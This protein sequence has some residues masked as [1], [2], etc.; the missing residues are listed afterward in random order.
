MGY[1]EHWYN[2]IA[3]VDVIEKSWKDIKWL[4]EKSIRDKTIRY[5]NQEHIR[6]LPPNEF[7]TL[8]VSLKSYLSHIDYETKIIDT[9]FEELRQKVLEE[10]KNKTA[11]LR[12]I[13]E[14]RQIS[15]AF[16]TRN[17]WDVSRYID[18]RLDNWMENFERMIWWPNNFAKLLALT[19][20]WTAK[21]L[22]KW[23]SWLLRLW[24]EISSAS[25]EYSNW[26][27]S[28]GEKIILILKTIWI[29]WLRAFWMIPAWVVSKWLSTSSVLPK[30][31][32]ALEWLEIGRWWKI[33][34]KTIMNERWSV[35]L[36]NWKE[37]LKES[38][39]I[40]SKYPFLKEYK[41]F[42]WELRGKDIFWE[43]QNA[44]IER[45]PY[46]EDLVVKI[47]KPWKVDS[48][49]LEY[50]SHEQFYITLRKWAKEFKGQ[51]SEEIKIPYVRKWLQEKQWIFEMEKIQWQNLATKFYREHYS[52]ELSKYPKKYLDK[53]TDWQFEVLID[54]EKLRK[55][56][57]M[58]LDWDFSGK[59]ISKEMKYFFDSKTHWTELW[60]VLDFL[61]WKWLKHTDLHPW[62]VMV[63]NNWNTFIIDFWK[64]L[65]KSKR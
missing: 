8:V 9:K 63:D 58:L 48:L 44:I 49:E 57:I 38:K 56:P 40:Y 24:E 14:A 43:W 31:W 22:W 59:M 5:L 29:E 65:I 6:K 64:V 17:P 11:S 36:R 46:R 10:S 55:V 32:R 25:E 61:E 50:K 37:A 60:N 18:S 42:L 21:Q 27:L 26:N 16:E 4:Q 19:S 23:M 3:K 39:E 45:H 51:I 34:F 53:L 52:K 54:K 30:L 47:A 15:T 2:D 20:F 7:N 28:A 33:I 13:Y 35:V 12:E 41:D 1:N 62:N